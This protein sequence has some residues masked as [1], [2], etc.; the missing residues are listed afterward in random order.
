[1]PSP[2]PYR[3]TVWRLTDRRDVV[4]SIRHC[5]SLTEALRVAE[6]L[7]DA[8]RIDSADI[9]ERTDSGG[10]IHRQTVS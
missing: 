4:G 7:L 3:L 2:C 6:R 1:M 5:D 9:E 8:G 10:W